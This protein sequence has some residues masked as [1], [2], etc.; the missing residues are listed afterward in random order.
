M[1]EPDEEYESSADS[2]GDV[3]VDANLAAAD[4]L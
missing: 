2:A 4:S 1:G 3:A